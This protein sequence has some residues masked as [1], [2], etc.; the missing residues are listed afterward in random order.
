MIEKNKRL[1]NFLVLFM[2]ITFAAPVFSQS[3]IQPWWLALEQGKIKYRNGDYGSALLS[4]EDA[5]RQRRAMYEQ[6]ER[7]FIN[8]LSVR[9]V[10]GIGDALDLVERYSNERYYTAASAALKELFYRVPRA[11]LNNSAAAALQAIGK[12]KDYPEAEYWIG[13]IYRVEGELSL[14]LSQ[15]RKAYAM[16]ELFEDPGFGT[17]LSYKIASI[18]MTRQEYNEMIRVLQSIITDLDTLWMNAVRAESGAVTNGSASTPVPYAQASASFVSQA[19]TRTLENDGI[20]RFL[21]LYRY[22]NGVVEQAHRQLGFFYAVTGR[23][24]AQQHLMFAFLIQNTTIIEEARRR[25]YGFTFTNLSDLAEEINKN[26]LLLSYIDA[27]EYYK[28]AY[29]LGSSLYRNGK[30]AVAR[31]LW[32]FLASQPG[33]GEWRNRA[34]VQLRSPHLEPV[35]EMP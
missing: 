7:D 34:V 16:R 4:F 26:A 18:L 22:D 12:L 29:Y 10:R 19:M 20:D 13:E 1:I 8:L 5:R 32:T 15:F 3:A 17:E 23:P 11:S 6:M 14:A 9:D 35:I 25:Q 24:S 27:V 2:L 28:T 30:T 33:A 31:S 21:E